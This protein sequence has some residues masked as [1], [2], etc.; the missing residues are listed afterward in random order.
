MKLTLL[1]VVLWSIKA[2][3]SQGVIAARQE[4]ERVQRLINTGALPAAKI[5]DAQ[6]ILD[7]ALDEEVLERTLYGH[8]EETDEQQAADMLRAAQ[9]RVDRQ[10]TKVTRINDLIARDLASPV[11]RVDLERELSNRE[12]AL[13]QA[14]VRAALLRE[15]A[16]MAHAEQARLPGL[17]EEKTSG[18]HLIE[19]KELKALTLA[20]EKQFSEPFPISAKG[21]TAVHRALGLDHTGRVDVAVNPDSPEGIWLREYLDQKG[22]PYYAFR[23]AMVGKATAPHIHI[24]PGSTRL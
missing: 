3:E 1:F 17:A 6:L 19:P 20:F 16:G 11:D 18:D 12:D 23:V 14:T 15:V 13:Q 5:A 21:M 22:I 24:G 7:D 4:M 2:E 8:I 9:S 10:Q